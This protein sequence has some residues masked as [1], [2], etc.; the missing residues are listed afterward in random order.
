MTQEQ[1]D[2]ELY[3]QDQERQHAEAADDE[4][5]VLAVL[6]Q[7]E[8][9]ARTVVTYDDDGNACYSA[10]SRFKAGD[11]AEFYDRL[12]EVSDRVVVDEVLHDSE[13]Y[14]AGTRYAVRFEGDDQLFVTDDSH[15]TEVTR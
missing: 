1:Y 12:T 14:G 15:L 6:S 3:E 11:V 13:H 10:P 4:A 2:Q 5:A 7:R 8:L 9:E